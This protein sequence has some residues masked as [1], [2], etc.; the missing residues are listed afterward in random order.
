VLAPRGAPLP[1]TTTGYRSHF[2]PAEELATEGGP[3]AF[4]TAWLDRE[5]N[6]KAW[7]KTEFAWRQLSLDL[8]APVPARSARPPARTPA[9]PA[10]RRP[11]Q[12]NA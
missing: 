7:E 4:V 2:L 8:T 5:A 9:R 11:G 6:S 1:I 10:R 3:V 12:G